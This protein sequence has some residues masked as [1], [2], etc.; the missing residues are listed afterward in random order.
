MEHPVELH[1][2]TV[3][4]AERNDVLTSKSIALPTRTL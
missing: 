4:D 2:V 3:L 1:R